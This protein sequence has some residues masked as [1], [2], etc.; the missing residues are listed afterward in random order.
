MTG[1]TMTTPALPPAML[2]DRARSYL[3]AIE[4]GVPFRELATF[5]TADC[6][7]EEFPNRLTQKGA[8]RTLDDIRAAAERG[9]KAVEGQRYE[10]LHAVAQ[11]NTV[12]LEVRWSGR[13]LL[14]VGS[15]APGSTMT[16]RFAMFLD[17]SGDRI[18]RQRN[19]DCF[20]PF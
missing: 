16:A 17:F 4:Q 15:L 12:A 11:G 5:L 18:A 1:E 2:V 13:L 9:S 6:V 3:R 20:D 7:Q 8:R 19:Y 10:V 14:P